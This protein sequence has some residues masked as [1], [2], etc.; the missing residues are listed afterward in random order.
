[1]CA[2]GTQ[3]VFLNSEPFCSAWFQQFSVLSAGVH[4]AATLFDRGAGH[5]ALAES[6]LCEQGAV[7]RVSGCQAGVEIS[8]VFDQHRVDPQEDISKGHR[9]MRHV[10]IRPW[11]AG[12]SGGFCHS[13]DKR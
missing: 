9:P 7:L 13:Q 11:I 12:R 6:S 10:L 1:M 5:I 2:V 8:S 4:G 3:A